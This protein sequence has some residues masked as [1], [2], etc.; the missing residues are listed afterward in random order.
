MSDMRK[1]FAFLNDPDTLAVFAL[2]VVV[3]GLV[4]F[5]IA[6]INWLMQ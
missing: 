3:C 2:L 6:V 1:F 5:V 4:R